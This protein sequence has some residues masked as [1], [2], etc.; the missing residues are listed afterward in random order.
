[1]KN[2]VKLVNSAIMPNEG[3]YHCIKIKQEEFASRAR[4]A[5]KNGIL[6]NYVGYQQTLD[7]VKKITEINELEVN[8]GMATCTSGDELL[9]I[10][11]NRRVMPDEKGNIEELTENDFEFYIVKYMG[12]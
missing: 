9:V 1:M 8:R 4:I 10:K 6:E 11:L 12:R 5:Y 2:K 7:Y 3:V